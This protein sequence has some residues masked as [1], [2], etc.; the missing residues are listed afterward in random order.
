MKHLYIL[1][2]LFGLI[3]SLLFIYINLDNKNYYNKKIFVKRILNEWNIQTNNGY[4]KKDETPPRFVGDYYLSITK[5][6]NYNNHIHLHLKRN[7]HKNDNQYCIFYVIKKYNPSTNK[8]H[9]SDDILI[10]IQ[11]NPKAV[12]FDMI[13][14]YEEFLH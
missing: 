14:K 12:V 2:C 9:H 1:V 10:D 11:S 8:I 6:D 4:I 13:K 7:C 3:A 5:K